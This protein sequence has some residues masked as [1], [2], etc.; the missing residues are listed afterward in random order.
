MDNIGIE[1]RAPERKRGRSAVR[2]I[3]GSPV[4]RLRK[5]RRVPNASLQESD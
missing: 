4:M 2:S 3:I 5:M 1:V